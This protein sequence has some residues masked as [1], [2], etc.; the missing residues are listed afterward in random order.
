MSH[1]PGQ[2]IAVIGSGISGLS[3]AWALKDV[4]DVVLYEQDDRLGGHSNTVTLDHKGKTIAVDTGFIVY[5]PSNYPN[6]ISLFDHLGVESRDTDMSFA[7]SSGA[8]EWSSNFP[9]GVFADR[10]NLFRSQFIGML[11]DIARFNAR[12]RRDA[13]NSAWETRSLSDYLADCGLSRNFESLY[14][15]PMAAAIWSAG[16]DQIGDMPAGTFLRFL[17]NHNLL[18]FAQPSWRTV[19]GGS[20]VY[21]GKIAAGLGSRIKRSTPVVKITRGPDG[22]MVSDAGRHEARFDQVIVAAHS[23]QTLKLVSDLDNQ[24]RHLL[25]SIRYTRNTALL[26]Q[27]A[28]QMPRLRRAWGSWNSIQPLATDKPYVTYWMNQLQ[29]IDQD[30]QLF[31]TLNGPEPRDGTVRGRF[32][33]AHPHFDLPALAAQKQ[34]DQVQ[35]RGGLWYAGAWLGHGFHEDGIT[36]GLRV[37]HRLGGNPGFDMV[38]HRIPRAENAVGHLTPSHAAA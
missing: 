9:H 21:V 27:D 26:H 13:D 28:S 3:A 12:G 4:H 32:D 15:R 37:A 35:G 6:L 17:A 16:L 31:V 30:C 22:I 8:M 29:G 7:C 38:D 19:V 5:N 11:A 10:S 24:E 25:S 33:Y 1:K 34:F 2:K 23:D 18:Q 20:Q 36:S 14:L